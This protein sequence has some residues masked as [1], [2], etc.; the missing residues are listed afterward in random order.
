MVSI[1]LPALDEE[2]AIAQTIT[3]LE[4][5]LRAAGMDFEIIVVNDGSTD[6][7]EEIARHH[8]AK[9]VNHLYRLGYGRSLKD[10]I[11]A[12][13]HD[14]IAILDAD[15]TYPIDQLPSLINRYR[16]GFDLIVGRRSGENYEESWLKSPLRRLLRGVVEF[17][18]GQGIPD[19]NSGMRVFSRTAIL[20]YF[21]QLCD[22]FSFTTSQ[23][24]AYLMT[25]K[26]VGY[27][28]I[29]YLP[30]IGTK[31]VRLFRDSLRTLQ[32]IV[33]SVLYYNPIKIFLLLTLGAVFFGAACIGTAICLQSLSIFLLGAG[34]L[35]T[36]VLIFSLG[37]LADQMRQILIKIPPKSDLTDA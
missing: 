22:T 26:Y 15:G 9:V 12:A 16:E 19:V 7:T 30:R 20:P 37:L 3:G 28:P 23:T 1:V 29:S 6:R 8:G 31:K 2:G 21:D 14:T 32:Y 5:T 18:A 4:V 36:S 25:G 24:L 10:G 11:L 35:L 34:S 27:H 33:Q 13:A 17:V